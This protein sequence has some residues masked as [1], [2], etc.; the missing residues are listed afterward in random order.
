MFLILRQVAMR[1]LGFEPKKE[2]IKK[3]IAE[4]DKDGTGKISFADFLAIMTQKMVFKHTVWFTM[5]SS[6]IYTSASYFGY[7]ITTLCFYKRFGRFFF[8]FATYYKLSQIGQ[9]QYTSYSLL[10]LGL[11]FDWSILSLNTL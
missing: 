8:F 5:P 11:Y 1:A 7:I 9:L 4:V 3:M 6:C 2:E 10:D